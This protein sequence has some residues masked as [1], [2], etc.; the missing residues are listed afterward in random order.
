M[1]HAEKNK[2]VDAYSRAEYLEER[3]DLMHWFS[4]WLESQL[5]GNV[6]GEG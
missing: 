1:H 5:A 3:K 6:L 4:G 2:I